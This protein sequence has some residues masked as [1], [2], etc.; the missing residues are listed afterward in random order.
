MTILSR[1]FYFTAM[2]LF[3]ISMI[4]TVEA[5]WWNPKSWF[6]S[7]RAK[8]VEVLI[9]TTNHIKSKLLADLIQYETNQPI[10]LLPTGNEKDKMYFL[11][12]THESDEVSEKDF[13]RFIDFLQ[14]KN[15]LFLG[16]ENYAPSHYIDSI[17]DV[18]GAWLIPGSNWQVIARSAGDMLRLKNLE[19]DYLVL[20]NQLDAN[21][22]IK[23][24]AST[25]T[26]GG[27]MTKDR[28]WKSDQSN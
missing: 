24:P 13:V 21:G 2:V 17:K 16:D 9:V 1:R 12:P 15:V 20:I 10:L 25:Q 18:V 26:Y 27:F 14:P 3:S 28:F 11:L 19:L 4:T 23:P 8:R 5:Q 22:Q 6:N 7:Q